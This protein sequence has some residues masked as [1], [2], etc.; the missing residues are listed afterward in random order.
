MGGAND[1]GSR[2]ELI[3]AVMAAEELRLAPECAGAALLTGMPVVHAP[4]VSAVS[5]K[6]HCSH[7][8]V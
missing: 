1:R 8:Q 7:R 6:S 2:A 5:G 4:L 3:E